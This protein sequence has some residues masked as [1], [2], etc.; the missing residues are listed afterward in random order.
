MQK[1][2][3]LKLRF[4]A[5]FIVLAAFLMSSF[6]ITGQIS[7]EEKTTDKPQSAKEKTTDKSQN[8][9]QNAREKAQK[10]S[11]KLRDIQKQ[12]LENNPELKKQQN[13]LRNLQKEKLEQMVPDNASKQDKVKAYRKLRQDKQLQERKKQFWQDMKG[14]MEKE[15]P[16]TEEYIKNLRH[17]IEKRKNQN[18]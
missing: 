3:K 2:K 16:K 7:A 1:L 15:D 18:V 14:A 11:N 12:A 8:E 9:M 10:Y 4:G 17:E 13:E 5:I 6:L